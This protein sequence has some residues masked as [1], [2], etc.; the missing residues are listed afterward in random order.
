MTKLVLL[1][2]VLAACGHKD[3]PSGPAA[4]KP[5]AAAD[6]DDL[7][8]LDCAKVVD[9]ADVKPLFADGVAFTR[10]K[11]NSGCEILS[12]KLVGVTFVVMKDAIYGKAEVGNGQPLAGFGDKAWFTGDPNVQVTVVKGGAHC[13]ASLGTT[14]NVN[15]LNELAKLST[16][17]R[18]KKLAAICVKALN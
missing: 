11:W 16:D 18:A 17:D 13:V 14:E 1:L 5:G 10:Q 9:D 6:P 12:A 8:P 3:K 2:A 15:E 4:D 7:P